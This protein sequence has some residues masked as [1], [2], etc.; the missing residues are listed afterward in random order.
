MPDRPPS[1]IA[2]TGDRQPADWDTLARYLAGE[3]NDAEAT[4][5]RNWLGANP[6]DAELIAALNEKVA[7]AAPAPVAIDVESAL[8][9]VNTIRKNDGIQPIDSHRSASGPG[10][11]TG[12]RRA[13][14]PATRW[15]VSLPAIAA[16][17]LLTLSVGGWL[18]LRDRTT[19]PASGARPAEFATLVGE[20]D[21]VR[22]EDGS[23]VVLGPHSSIRVAADFGGKQRE[24][25]MSGEAFFDVVHDDAR[26]FVVRAGS[27]TIRDVGT[28]FVVR[29]DGIDGV[30]VAVTEG[31]VALTASGDSAGAEVLLQAGDRGRVHPSG[32][33]ITQ[34]G[35]AGNDDLAWMEGSLVFREA[36]LTEVIASLQRWYG[37]ELRISEPALRARH[38]TATF[39]GEPLDRVLEVI[40][41]ALG[42]D[43]ERR[44]NTAIVRSMRGRQRAR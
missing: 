43:I 8:R 25:E 28:H 42:A 35:S 37:I 17:G 34:R 21:S 23:L 31:V 39:T 15:R 40:G 12:E 4:A 1:E 26:P 24:V 7:T 5:I 22:L 19:D 27:A 33:T 9:A 36:P 11:F 16:A 13:V 30:S 18:A 14:P 6:L 2:H 10:R 41:L 32:K 44:G 3:S 20:R 29:S 38:I